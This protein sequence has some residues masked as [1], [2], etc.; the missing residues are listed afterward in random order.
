[1]NAPAFD[2]AQYL[3][4]QGQGTIAATTGWGI[5]GSKEPTSPDTTITV[6]DFSGFAPDPDNSLYA[7]SV[8]VRVRGIG[9]TTVYAKA[10]SVRDTLIEPSDFTINSVKYIGVWQQGSIESL[11]YDDNDRVILV[12]NFNII[13]QEV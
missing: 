6:Y 13:R 3:Q 12:M 2:I 11:G 1:M 4:A 7:P 5:Y 10:E 8:Q 9:Y